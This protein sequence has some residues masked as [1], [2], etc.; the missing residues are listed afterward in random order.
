MRRR[1]CARCSRLSA[2]RRLCC[3]CGARTRRFE[4]Q[5]RRSRTSRGWVA[6]PRQKARCITTCTQTRASCCPQ[7]AASPQARRWRRPRPCSRARWRPRRRAARRWRLPR[8]QSP[9]GSTRTTSAGGSRSTASWCGALIPSGCAKRF[10]L[11]RRQW[12]SWHGNSP[13]F[14]RQSGPALASSLSVSRTE[15]GCV[16]LWSPV[17]T[18]T[19]RLPQDT[20]DRAAFLALLARWAGVLALA[21][22]LPLAMADS[23]GTGFGAVFAALRASAPKV[24]LRART[25][26]GCATF[27]PADLAMWLDTHTADALADR[28]TRP[29]IRASSTARA[30]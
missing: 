9:P 8:A 19:W 6:P 11:S 24:R 23:L 30:Q 14:W 1:C 29:P 27:Q 7:S 2:R 21:A 16:H 3:T 4:P 17:D 5:R 13:P 22:V 15:F 10:P 28:R 20:V 18:P 12:G 26:F 25:A